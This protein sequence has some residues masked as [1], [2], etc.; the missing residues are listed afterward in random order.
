MC[1]KTGDYVVWTNEKEPAFSC[2]KHLG[3]V[4]LSVMSTPKR[5]NPVKV[6]IASCDDAPCEWS[7]G[8]KS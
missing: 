8:V 7:D 5:V 2:E 3:A 4:V 1:K 6:C